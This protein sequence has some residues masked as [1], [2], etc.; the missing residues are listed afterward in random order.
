MRDDAACK[1][2]RLTRFAQEYTE[3]GEVLWKN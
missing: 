2:G 1:G 3:G